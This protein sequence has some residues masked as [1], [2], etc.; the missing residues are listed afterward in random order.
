VSLIPEQEPYR[1]LLAL[2]GEQLASTSDLPTPDNP[3]TTEAEQASEQPPGAV[4]FHADW[5]PDA[6]RRRRPV[7]RFDSTPPTAAQVQFAVQAGLSTE[8]S[9]WPRPI[10]DDLGLIVGVAAFRVLGLP[11][12][13]YRW[14]SSGAR[15]FLAEERD[16]WAD[17]LR[18]HHPHCPVLLLICGDMLRACRGSSPHGFGDLLVRAGA[19]G[20]MAWLA[21]I[22]VGL[23]GSV[24]GVAHRR[25]IAPLSRSGGGFLG[26]IC[27]VALGKGA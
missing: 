7:H 8:R 23:A 2:R 16:A 4:G 24:H 15:Q 10:H 25:A 17:G 11:A 9:Q 6:I 12:G 27:T 5:L 20:H 22:S 1:R 14:E 13:L 19:V 21:A 18:D 3:L 26:H